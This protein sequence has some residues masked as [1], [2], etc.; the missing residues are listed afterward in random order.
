MVYRTT[1]I[2]SHNSTVVAIF[3]CVYVWCVRVWCVFV[4]V[5]SRGWPPMFGR[6]GSRVASR[7]G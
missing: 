2:A 4:Y 6:H 7:G 5:S 3:H 1:A